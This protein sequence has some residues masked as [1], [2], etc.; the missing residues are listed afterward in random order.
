[1]IFRE[2]LRALKNDFLRSFFFWLT[3]VLTSMFIF[4]FFSIAGTIEEQGIITGV[5]VLVVIVCSM[6]IFSANSFFIHAKAKDMAVRLICGATYSFLATYLLIQTVILLGLAIPIG[7]GGTY[8]LI[9][10]MNQLLHTAIVIG[11]DAVLQTSFMIGYIL[12]WIIL[13]NLSFAYKSAASMMLNGQSTLLHGSANVFYMGSVSQKSKAIL[14][15]ILFILP[16]F[17]I[18]FVNVPFTLGTI[19]SFA[20]IYGMISMVAIHFLDQQ[21]DQK[22]IENPV[23]IVSLGF[24]RNDLREL[25]MNLLLFICTALIFF[26]LATEVGTGS[27]ERLLIQIS[28][29][30]MNLLLA[31][32]IMFKYATVQ[33]TRIKHFKTM[34]NLGY[35]EEEKKKII[36]KEVH[37]LYSFVMIL[38]GIYVGVL[39]VG[40]VLHQNYDLSD[41]IVG[42]VGYFVPL[43]LCMLISK[44]YYKYSL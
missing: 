4:L 38:G 24:L 30:M 3:F 7:I 41:T 25:K 2:A 22:K 43:C 23:G 40:M 1:M 33:S 14:Y 34:S 13:L 39:L 10:L 19:I 12:F 5:T 37:L 29:L 36:R 35:L 32:A 28:Y 21:I 20:G 17:V 27:L 26:S 31:L 44:Q 42:I 8:L 11:S 9:P 15:V 16:V 18:L 6:D